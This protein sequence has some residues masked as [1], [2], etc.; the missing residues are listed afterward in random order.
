MRVQPTILALVA[1]LVALSWSTTA[2]AK[3]RKRAKTPDVQR[4][5]EELMGRALGRSE[6]Y[7]ELGELCDTIGARISGSPELERAVQWSAAQMRSDGLEVSLEPVDVPRWIRGQESGTV[8]APR[9]EDV[10]ILALGNSVG[11]GGEPLEADV[12]V[13]SSFTELT[14]R[15]EEAK[16]KWILYDVPFTTYGETVQ[17]RS[18]GAS[19]AAAVGGVGAMVR[20]VSP[21]SLD[22]PHTGALRYSDEQA[23]LPAVAVPLETATWLHRLQDRG[24]TPRFRY[25]SEARFEADAPSH[26][27]VGQI[28]GR[29]HP[30]EVLV[31]G[32]HLDS[33]DVGQGAQ[34]DG[35]G[36]VT[37]MEAG[38]LLAELPFAPARTVRVVLYTNEENGLRGGR[39]YAAAH[40]G[41]T[42][43]AALEDDTGSGAPQGFRVDVRN[44]DGERD[45]AGTAAM[46]EALSAWTPHLS[47]VGSG[48]FFE[49]YS[50]ADIGPIIDEDTVGFGLDHDMTGYW[51]I[52]HT[53]ADTFEKV[54]PEL[55]RRNVA[56]TT[57]F[58]WLLAEQGLPEVSP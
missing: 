22:T 5:A 54:D 48:R 18:R 49:G 52:H 31:L 58:A 27:V 47:A 28:T 11:T 50:G 44:T 1:P 14:E 32:C 20:S 4:T 21:V 13:V 33:W 15:A 8:T 19:A 43:I 24:V 12:L 38:A 56:A 34:D 36:C 23:K 2:D 46:V 3:P 25:T 40:E 39:A 16:G 17:Y 7:D 9:V 57:V 41:E 37:V 29:T 10:D 45:T 53:D 35:A 26:N 30:D 42:I 6:A 55:V 51:P